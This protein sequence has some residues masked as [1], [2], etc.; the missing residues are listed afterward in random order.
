MDHVYTQFP[1]AI[2]AGILAMITYTGLV[3]V[4]V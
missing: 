2:T 1:L 4:F 3:I